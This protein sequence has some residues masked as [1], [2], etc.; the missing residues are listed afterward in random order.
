VTA[1]CFS[2]T[3]PRVTVTWTAAARAT[4]YTVLQSTTSDTSGFTVVATG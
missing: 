4:S 2:P 1:T 3:T